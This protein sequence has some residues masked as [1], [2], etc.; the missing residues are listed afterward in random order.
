M[1]KEMFVLPFVVLMYVATWGFSGKRA[2]VTTGIFAIAA[3]ITVAVKVFFGSSMLA[4]SAGSFAAYALMLGMYRF[5]VE[6]AR[7]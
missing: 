4:F 5:D 3:V 7:L 1:I 2:I 6:A